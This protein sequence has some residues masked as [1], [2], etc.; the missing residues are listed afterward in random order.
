MDESMF[1]DDKETTN[2]RWFRM[3]LYVVAKAQMNAYD[4][5]N[6]IYEKEKTFKSNREQG[7]DKASE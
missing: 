3:A 4:L 6:R 1:A 7:V 2:I 5:N